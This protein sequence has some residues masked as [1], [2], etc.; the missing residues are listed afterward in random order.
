MCHLL[1]GTPA[2]CLPGNRPWAYSPV[3]KIH[4]RAFPGVLI[5]LLCTLLAL[6]FSPG[7]GPVIENIAREKPTAPATALCTSSAPKHFS[8]EYSGLIHVKVVIGEMPDAS[9][10][11]STDLSSTPLSKH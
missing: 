5:I 3:R 10:Q 6:A 2:A 9:L 7:F 11:S 4:L 8:F 1:A